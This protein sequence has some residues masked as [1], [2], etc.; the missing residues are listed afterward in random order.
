[1]FHRLFTVPLIPS[2]GGEQ[3]FIH[4]NKDSNKN[5]LAFNNSS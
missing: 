2:D 5:T 1:M 3:A 4:N